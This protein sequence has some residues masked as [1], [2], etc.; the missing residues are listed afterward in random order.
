MVIRERGWTGEAERNV[1]LWDLHEAMDMSRH[2]YSLVLLIVLFGR[3]SEF[4]RE[5]LPVHSW[6]GERQGKVRG[7]VLD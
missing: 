2:G 1:I 7:K 6:L 4:R 5:P 3:S